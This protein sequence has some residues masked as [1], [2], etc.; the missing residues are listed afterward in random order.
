M[1]VDRIAGVFT[2]CT[3]VQF[4]IVGHCLYQTFPILNNPLHLGIL[5]YDHKGGEESN[6]FGSSHRRVVYSTANFSS[7][8]DC[9]CRITR[10]LEKFNREENGGA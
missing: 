1:L 9:Y 4:H 2:I 5:L 8:M 3:V 10:I 6:G 7:F